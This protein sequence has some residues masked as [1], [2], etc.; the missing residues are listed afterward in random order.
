ME[1]NSF[2][3]CMADLQ[4]GSIFYDMYQ[5]EGVESNYYDESNSAEY[6]P[7]YASYPTN[8]RILNNDTEQWTSA[9]V[10]GQDVQTVILVGVFDQN[11]QLINIDSDSECQIS[12]DDLTL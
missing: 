10:S 11:G 1:G 5:P 6:G 8:L 4:G 3:E 2:S 12:T 7:D 9:F